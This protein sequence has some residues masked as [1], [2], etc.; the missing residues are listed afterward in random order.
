MAGDGA[1]WRLQVLVD[2]VWFAPALIHQVPVASHLLRR[3][4]E[5]IQVV[6]T[7]EL[8]AARVPQRRI[9]SLH[10]QHVQRR[11]GDLVVGAGVSEAPGAQRLDQ[12]L[13]RFLAALAAFVR[14][15]TEP[16]QLHRPDAATNAHV[17]SA[18]G[19]VV[20]HADLLDQPHRVIQRQ[21]VH[22][23]ADPQSRR[24][25]RQRRQEHV[26]RRR[27]IQRGEVV[28]G[29]VVADEAQ[30]LGFLEQ[31]DLLLELPVERNA[32]PTLEVI[33]DAEV[34]AHRQQ[35]M[36]AACPWAS[37]QDF[38]NRVAVVTGASGIGRALVERCAREGM[39]VVLA[40]VE[41]APLEAAAAELRASGA[42][43]LAVPTDVSDPQAVEELPAAAPIL[44]L[45]ACTCCAT[46]PA[47]S[48]NPPDPIWEATPN[49]WRWILG[50]N[51]W[52]VIH[53]QRSFVPRMLDSGDEGWIVNTASMGGLV[54]GGVVRRVQARGGGDYRGA[55]QRPEA[56]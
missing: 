46:T 14:V 40:D 29:N 51:V 41:A 55:V 34:D 36:P 9:W 48:G 50:V 15:Q 24:R 32:R 13:Q 22:H 53:G 12:D 7:S 10:R 6:A 43:V 1:H 17:Q 30:L 37:M 52:G 3:S 45:A 19:Q 35:A 26:R 5:E 8:D 44:P 27:H 42:E 18:R 49:D 23:G 16:L 54:P 20:Q 2:H 47:L 39:R 38:S 31:L 4:S 28:L 21:D 11:F 25:L 56:T 33:P